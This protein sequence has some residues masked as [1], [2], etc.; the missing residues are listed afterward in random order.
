MAI[1]RATFTDITELNILVNS[2]YRGDFSKKGW[3]TEADLLDGVRTDKEMLAS[4]LAK[5]NSTILLYKKKDTLVGCVNLQLHNDKL[6]LGMLTVN[7]LQ[8]GAGVGKLLLSAA[9]DYARE[10]NCP[11]IYMT[12]ISKRKELVDW[13]KR[14]GYKDTGERKPLLTDNPKFGIPATPLEFIVMQKEI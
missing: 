3:T 5:E 12:V 2:A 7:P 11:S 8:Q 13:Y 6:Y 10:I 14:H 1:A 9:E 4:L